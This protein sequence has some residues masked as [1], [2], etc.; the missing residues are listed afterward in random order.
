MDS[1]EK[2]LLKKL[3]KKV[4]KLEEELHKRDKIIQKM[5]GQQGQPEPLQFGP[6]PKSKDRLA[7]IIVRKARQRAREKAQYDQTPQGQRRTSESRATTEEIRR[8]FSLGEIM[9]FVAKKKIPIG[10]LEDESSGS[11]ET[12]IVKE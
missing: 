3:L 9:I 2:E 10:N 7:N 6:A 8:N 1:E 12:V 5:E 11:G 4:D